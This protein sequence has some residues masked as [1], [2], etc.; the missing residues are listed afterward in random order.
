MT[1]DQTK[2]IVFVMGGTM[3]AITLL[4]YGGTIAGAGSKGTSIGKAGKQVASGGESAF[5]KLWGVGLLT[6]V[7]AF[8]AD[9]IPEVV[10]P[11]ALLILVAYIYKNKSVI[12]S[13]FNSAVS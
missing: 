2:G 3:A 7:M 12:S 6:V 11:V 10:G 5:K 1:S 9:M 8:G 13:G 4:E